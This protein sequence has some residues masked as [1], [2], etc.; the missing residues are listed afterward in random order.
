MFGYNVGML[1]LKFFFLKKKEK[2]K[3][4]NST[5]CKNGNARIQKGKWVCIL[6]LIHTQKKKIHS[7]AKKQNRPLK[8]KYQN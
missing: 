7:N 3:K 4:V 6:I 1:N 2:R 5:L 8:S